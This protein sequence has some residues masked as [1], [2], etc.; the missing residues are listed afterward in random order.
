MVRRYSLHKLKAQEGGYAAFTATLIIMVVM[1]LIVLGFANNARNE[2]QRGLNNQLS[3]AAYYAAESGINDAY[4]VI[5]SDLASG[6]QP[7]AQTQQ[8]Q[9]PAYNPSLATSVLGPTG[10]SANNYP[11]YSC[12]LVN[13][14]PPS[15]QYSPLDVGHG[16]VVPIFGVSQTSGRPVSVRTITISWQES[17]LS[18]SAVFTGCPTSTY[19]FPPQANWSNCGAGMLQVDLV[20]ASGWSTVQPFQSATQSYF[21]EPLYNSSGA[22]H[23]TSE[24]VGTSSNGVDFGTQCGSSS[25]GEYDCTITLQN[26]PATIFGPPGRSV[27]AY[28]LHI[29]P[30]YENADVTI[31]AAGCIGLGSC[32]R[33]VDLASA[34]AS[35]DSTGQDGSELK[36]IEER[37]S[38]NPVG[39]NNQPPAALQTQ[40]SLTKQFTTRPG[41]VTT[42]FY[43]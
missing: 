32:S 26:L 2:Q 28:Y 20:P 15:L 12:L 43:P 34:Q 11:S 8:C 39:D 31:T 19:N 41:C 14:T 3:L 42:C 25:G 13:P 40:N 6:I 36:R 16:Q 29:V 5:K 4:A 22:G 10:A 9:G 21:L 24:N 7:P 17:G 35:V 33:P 1:S 38:I 27:A 30:I 23:N 18:P 37:I